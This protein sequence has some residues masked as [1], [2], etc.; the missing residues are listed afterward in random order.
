MGARHVVSTILSRTEIFI[1]LIEPKH[2]SD[3]PGWA[4]TLASARE[5]YRAA[6]QMLGSMDLHTIDLGLLVGALFN[7]RIDVSSAIGYIESQFEVY[8]RV[9]NL[10]LDISEVADDHKML[11]ERSAKAIVSSA[12][13]VIDII[14]ANSAFV[15]NR[16]RPP[17]RKEPSA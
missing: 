1:S 14:D 2:P 13:R 4:G 16:R 3:R 15:Y 9:E 11:I 17:N 5:N 12:K 6:S 7:L 8:S 10:Q